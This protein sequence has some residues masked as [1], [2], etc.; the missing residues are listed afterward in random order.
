MLPKK[1]NFDT[2]IKRPALRNVWC[3]NP[4]VRLRKDIDFFCQ[5][6][7][8]HLK[9]LRAASARPRAIL[10]SLGPATCASV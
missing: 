6:T 3:N 4:T 2:A 10:A 8:N 9:K 1:F 5:N 7:V